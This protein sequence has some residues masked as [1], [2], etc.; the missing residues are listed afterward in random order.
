MHLDDG[1]AWQS[2]PCKRSHVS[3]GSAPSRYR[4]S[5]HTDWALHMGK[6]S[7]GE[8]WDKVQGAVAAPVPTVTEDLG[9]RGGTTCPVQAGAVFH[10]AA[11]VR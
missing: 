10:L 6:R 11:W 2:V 1:H 8:P 7:Q 4:V 3:A 9:L 5:H